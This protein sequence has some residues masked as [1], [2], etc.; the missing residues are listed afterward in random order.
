MGAAGRF[1]S[2][3]WKRRRLLFQWH[4]VVHLRAAARRS[5]VT[6]TCAGGNSVSTSPVQ[7]LSLLVAEGRSVV[8]VRKAIVSFL[9]MRNKQL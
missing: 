5:A 8:E 4:I 3:I 9:F 2:L 6:Y 7:L 1:G